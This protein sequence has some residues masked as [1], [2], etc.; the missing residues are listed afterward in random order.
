MTEVWL[1]IYILWVEYFDHIVNILIEVKY[2]EAY[3]V[4]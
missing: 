3:P 1:M 2:F 4:T